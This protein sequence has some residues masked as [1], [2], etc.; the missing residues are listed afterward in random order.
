MRSP[1]DRERLLDALDALPGV[2]VPARA[3]SDRWLR[4]P[5]RAAV[6]ARPGGVEPVSCLYTP[7]AEFADR[8]LIE[9]ARGCGRGCRFC[10]A[11]YVYRPPQQPITLLNSARAGGAATA[12]VH[13]RAVGHATADY[14][15][16]SRRRIGSQPD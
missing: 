14:R 3:G 6:G 7:D 13:Q 11:G 15:S 12:S 9:I 4:R 1:S 8:H 16:G 10:L 2:Y 5:D